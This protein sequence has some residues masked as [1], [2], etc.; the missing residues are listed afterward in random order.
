MVN[1]LRCAEL[2][3]AAAAAA[4]NSQL[5]NSWHTLALG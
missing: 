2:A 5:C 4:Y 3:T 1:D